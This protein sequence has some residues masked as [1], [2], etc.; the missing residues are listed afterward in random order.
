MAMRDMSTL[1]I[2][3]YLEDKS[4]ITFATEVSPLAVDQLL[5]HA[6]SCSV[7]HR[8]SEGGRTLDR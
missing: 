8:H 4:S 3:H 6:A 1:I 7:Y 5:M 2:L